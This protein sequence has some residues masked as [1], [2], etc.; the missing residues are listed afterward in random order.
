[1]KLGLMAMAL[2][3]LSLTAAEAARAED[4][5]NFDI[6]FQASLANDNM[7]YGLT[8]TDRQPYGMISLKPTYGIFYG[9]FS[10]ERL[11][12]PTYPDVNSGLKFGVG[13]TPS[14]GDKLSFDINVQRQYKP[15]NSGFAR[16]VPYATGTYAFSDAFS[17][18]LGLGYYLYDEPTLY[19]NTGEL[20]ASVDL[21]P[22][23]WLALHSE[24]S[25]DFTGYYNTGGPGPTT[26]Y[27]EA[28]A[29]ATVTL[30]KG[31]SVTGKLAY[32]D[33]MS[34]PGLPSYT[35][36]D[37]GVDW[38]ANDH[39]SLGLHYQGNDLGTGS[40]NCTAQSWNGECDARFMASVTINGKLSDL[41]K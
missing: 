11:N 3:A 27:L 9:T 19:P 2:A 21:T 5:S 10:A 7:T 36:Y 16:T 40:A 30:P 22:I 32:E 38:A 13:I 12:Y 23:D 8:N 1:M 29:S 14:I 17:A 28:I 15:A 20:Y 25:Y 4:A 6:E 24:T 41:K 33:Y 31:F 37:I 35:W 39:I 26:P 34:N 18:S